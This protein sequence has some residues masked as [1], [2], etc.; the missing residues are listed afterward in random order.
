MNY[1][2][3]I[4]FARINEAALAN[5]SYLEKRLPDSHHEGKRLHADTLN[6]G[7]GRSFNLNLET[8]AWHDQA[9]SESGGDAVS[10]VAAQE[11]IGQG[12]AARLI[13]DE[14]GLDIG[15]SSSPPPKKLARKELPE[16]PH[17]KIDWSNPAA[18][19]FYFNP[20]GTTQYAALRFE[21]PSYRKTYRLSRGALEPGKWDNTGIGGTPR[22]L[23]NL[24]EILNSDFVVV[25][26]G[27]N[28]VNTLSNMGVCATCNVGG[29]GKWRDEYSEYLKSKQ[30]LILPDN[31]EP[32]RKHAQQV[33]SSLQ[34]KAKSIKILELPGL[35]EKGDIIDWLKVPGNDVVKLRDLMDA[36]AELKPEE[37]E[38]TPPRPLQINVAD[39]LGTAYLNNYPPSYSWVVKNSLPTA[40]LGVVAGPPGAGKGTFCLQMSASLAA[41]VPILEHWEPV[42]PSKVIYLS[43]EDSAP[44]IHRRLH[45]SLIALSEHLREEAASRIVA[46][47]V[48][49]RVSLCQSDKCDLRISQNMEDL[50][51]IIEEFKPDVVFLDTLARFLNI[52]ENDNRAMTEACSLL[53]E[54]IKDYGCTIILLHHVNKVSGDCFEDDTALSAALTQTSIRGASALAGCVRWALLLA[55]MGK[56]LSEKTFGD[57]AAGKHAGSFVAVRVGKKNIG[58]PEPRFYFGRNEHGLLYPVEPA[59]KAAA[60]AGLEADAHR[61]AEEVR[62]RAFSGEP[63]LSLSRGGREVFDGWGDSRNKKATEKAIEMGLVKVAEKDKGWGKVLSPGCP[64][65]SQD[66]GMFNYD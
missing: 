53:E 50:R 54:L 4:D 42:K 16:L 64:E 34:G 45:H 17:N 20:D 38:Q 44:V 35:P 36:A 62:R 66:F 26:E 7:K 32:G 23:Y 58:A 10:L 46:I 5:P 61:L 51:A 8:G 47:P 9:T 60:D 40:C 57:L 2:Q 18:F 3:Q 15:S 37:S 19:Y 24:P 65:N 41:G 30:V 28:K 1:D 63:T 14:L 13:A 21:A 49:G 59:E 6:G 22:I 25:V 52:E 55:P 56:K 29:S 31:D 11:N 33:A 39:Y 27:E 48:Q 12:E 43:A